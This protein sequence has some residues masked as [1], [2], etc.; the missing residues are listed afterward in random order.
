M[1][2]EYPDSLIAKRRLRAQANLSYETGRSV[3]ISASISGKPI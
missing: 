3:P 1:C 2:F